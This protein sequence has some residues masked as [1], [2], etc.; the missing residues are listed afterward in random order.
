[1]FKKSTSTIEPCHLS[2]VALLQ[3]VAIRTYQE[4]FSDTNSEALL[5]QYYKESLNIEKLSAQLQNTNSEFYFLYATSNTS[6]S[7]SENEAKNTD[8]KL[9]GFLK[10]NVDSAQTD[11]FDAEALEVEKI[12]ILKD[13]LSQGLGKKL[14]SFAIERAIEQNKKYLWLGVWEHNFPAL[15]F[16]QKMGFE[17]FGEHDFNM[18]G[19][20]QKDLLLKRVL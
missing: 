20:I 5:Q 10:L 12:Y 6:E 3:Y 8:A 11:I 4:T 16:Y 2:Q 18:G 13:F 17:Q 19:D 7:I 9:A 1:M 15:T 14:I